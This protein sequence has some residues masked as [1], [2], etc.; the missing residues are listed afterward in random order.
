MICKMPKEPLYQHAQQVLLTLSSSGSSWFVQVRNLLLMYQLP[1]THPL[2]LLLNPPVKEAFK[3]LVKSK[4]IDYWETKLRLESTF[5][6]SL[7]Y[8]NSEYMSLCSTHRL[9]T[10]AGHK[11][12]VVANARIQLLFLS[13]QYPCAKWRRHWA[14]WS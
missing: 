9:W 11:T 10:T 6:S 13:F 5:L 4:V 1:H 3:K 14:R 2:I 7:V 8:F 12:H